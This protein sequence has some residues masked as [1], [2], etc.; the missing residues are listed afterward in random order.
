MGFSLDEEVCCMRF[1]RCVHG[2]YACV[3]HAPSVRKR[4][5]QPSRVSLIW[6]GGICIAMAKSRC[7]M[8]G[9]I[10]VMCEEDYIAVSLKR[11]GGNNI[12]PAGIHRIPLRH[13]LLPLLRGSLTGRWFWSVVV[14]ATIDQL[15]KVAASDASAQVPGLATLVLH[16]SRYLE[17]QG[18]GRREV[19]ACCW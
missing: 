5:C 2:L 8:S 17:R 7:M 16:L 6:W 13:G 10:L 18:Y 3:F 15:Q 1:I 11:Y 12:P 14:V 19:W 9:E 4:R